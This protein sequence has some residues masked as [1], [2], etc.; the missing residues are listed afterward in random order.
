M[1]TFD[2][3]SQRTFAVEVVE[4][5]RAAGWIAYWAGGCVR[6]QLLGLT[7]KDYDVATDAPPEQI[8]ELF[9]RRRTIPVG[10]AFGVMTV[11]G[12]KPAG[13]VEVATFRQDFGYSDG[14]RPDEVQFSTPELDAQ[15][16]DFT[17]NGLFYDPHEQRVIDFVGGRRDLAARVVRAI[18]DPVERFREDKLRMLRAV[19]FAATFRFELEPT[20]L[21][22]IRR[23][24]EQIHVVSQERIGA[25]MRRMLTHETQA[26]AA[27][28]LFDSGLL[29]ELLPEAAQLARDE[30]NQHPWQE[31]LRVLS[32][33][34]HTTM[35]VGLA[36]LLHQSG[37][38]ELAGEVGRRWRLKNKEVERT[39]W[40]L[41][42]LGALPA[43]R[44]MR[45]PRLQRLLISPGIDELLTL[46][47]AQSLPGDEVLPYLQ[48]KLRLPDEQLNPPPLLG[49]HDLIE[50]GVRPGPQFSTLLDAV[51]DAQLEQ[52][53]G[54]RDDALALV[55]RLL[56]GQ[57]EGPAGG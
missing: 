23:M 50:H 28:L 44:T 25:E 42:H 30:A 2:P 6:D 34:G 19:R 10:A 5:L 47:E 51:R 3:E 40:L 15:R 36:A 17:I 49:G 31:T 24:T 54:S 35:P 43:A 1:T 11:I 21:W 7:P 45:W 8:R 13:H 29:A 55:D 41:E 26:R 4:R 14:R 12:P 48:E 33:L 52:Q 9:G 32:D 46:Y 57:S 39:A 16:R 53:I 27:E 38:P 20:T 18:G 22:A 56:T 37:G